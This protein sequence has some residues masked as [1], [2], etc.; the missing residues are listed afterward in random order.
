MR[1]CFND[2]TVTTHFIRRIARFISGFYSN[3]MGYRDP[4]SGTQSL[5]LELVQIHAIF[6]LVLVLLLCEML[7]V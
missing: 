2:P 4:V 5:G 6:L 3:T 7:L 1:L